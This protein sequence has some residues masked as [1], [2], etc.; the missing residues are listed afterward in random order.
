M[1]NLWDSSVMQLLQQAADLVLLN[2]AWLVCALPLVTLGPASA[3]LY[4]TAKSIRAGGGTR[5]LPVFWEAFTH[6]FPHRA[7]AGWAVLLA[8]GVLAVD[9]LALAHGALAGRAMLFGVFLFL[10]ILLLVTASCLFPLMAEHDVGAGTGIRQA[11]WLGFRHLGRAGAAAALHA[12]PILLFLFMPPVFLLLIPLWT[13]GYF[14]MAASLSLRLLQ[15]VLR[16]GGLP[17]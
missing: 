1:K 5:V 7:L 10:S 13:A 8:G 3:A 14:A 2:M 6:R 12:L 17:L 11:F 4:T 15:P 16:E 9:F